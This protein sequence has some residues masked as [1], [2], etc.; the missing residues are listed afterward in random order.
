[1]ECKVYTFLG[2]KAMPAKRFGVRL[3]GDPDLEFKALLQAAAGGDVSTGQ[4]GRRTDAAAV[5][6]KLV[7]REFE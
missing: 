5:A 4:T 7:K 1:V 3:K 2:V 6:S